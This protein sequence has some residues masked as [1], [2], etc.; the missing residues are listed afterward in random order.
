MAGNLWSSSGALSVSENEMARVHHSD[1]RVLKYGAIHTCQLVILAQLKK[2]SVIL[3]FLINKILLKLTGLNEKIGMEYL[4]DIS[5][6]SIFTFI[7][8]S[9]SLYIIYRS[10]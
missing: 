3:S 4:T 10:I 8:L 9:L 1:F 6:P 5:V 7:S 2:I